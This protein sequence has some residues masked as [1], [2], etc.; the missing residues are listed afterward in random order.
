EGEIPDP[1]DPATFERSRVHPGPQTQAEHVQLLR[2]SHRLLDLRKSV[3]ALGSAQTGLHVHHA[4]VGETKQVLLLHRRVL[5]SPATLVILGFNRE[6]SSVTVRKPI[7]TWELLVEAF[8]VELG[9]PGLKLFP[10][11]VV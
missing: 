8:D 11:T 3:P 10:A 2:W 4:W 5:R 7:G 1:Q 9:D 6:Q